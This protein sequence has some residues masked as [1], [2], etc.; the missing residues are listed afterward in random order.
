M[1][2]ASDISTTETTESRIWGAAAKLFYDKGYHAT[3]MR[4]IASEVGIKA[5]SLY[6]HFPGKQDI[7]LRISLQ[8]TREL[9]EGA[10]A[11]LEGITDIEEA[12]R[13]FL[14]WH[15]EFHAKNK[16]ASRVADGQLPALSDENRLAVLEM[17]DAHEQ[18]FRDL[19]RRGAAELGWTVAD[20]R[21][22]SFGILTMCTE[23][24]AWFRDDGP[25]TA[26][27]IGD[28]YADFVLRGLRGDT[29]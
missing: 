4:D 19:L 2:T 14:Q 1:T 6:N 12:I 13:A 20:E 5:G 17:R 7:L 25:L 24:D 27:A 8:T 23:V 28:M 16:L 18:L 15:V 11:R 29:S 9:H 22:I 21:V 26:E 10:V 3:T